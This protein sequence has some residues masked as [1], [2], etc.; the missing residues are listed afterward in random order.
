MSE[1]QTNPAVDQIKKREENAV[2]PEPFLKNAGAIKT[3]D[4]QQKL[5]F[6]DSFAAKLKENVAEK[7]GIEVGVSEVAQLFGV[8]ESDVLEKDR[9]YTSWR[10]QKVVYN[11]PSKGALI[12]DI[13]TDQ[14][15]R[16]VAKDW[17][18][19]PP[20]QRFMITQSLRSFQDE[21]VFCESAILFNDEPVKSCCSS[22]RVF[23]FYC[24]GC[25]R[26]YLEFAAGDDRDEQIKAG[27]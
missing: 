7:A 23:T 20:K 27:N 14:T 16:E 24:D 3:R 25:D 8:A 10:I 11:W 12:F 15:L 22:Q 4:T 18:Q 5:A 2:Q 9:E 17:E 13:A 19:V 21:C 1:E 6:T 26:R